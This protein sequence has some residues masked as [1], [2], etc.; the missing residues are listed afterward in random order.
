VTPSVP[1]A[2]GFKPRRC[3]DLAQELHGGA[4]AVGA[5]DRGDGRQ[6]GADRSAPRWLPRAPAGSSLPITGTDAWCPGGR[7]HGDGALLDGHGD[8]LR[9]VRWT[10]GSAANRSPGWT[11]RLSSARPVISRPSAPAGALSL[12]GSSSD[13]RRIIAGPPMRLSGSGAG[14]SDRAAM[15]GRGAN[16]SAT[17]E[18]RASDRRR[19]GL[20]SSTPAS[21]RMISPAAGMAVQ[22]A[23]ANPWVSAVGWGRSIE[24]VSTYCGSSNG[25]TA[26]KVLK[27]CLQSTDRRYPFRRAGLARHCQARHIRGSGLGPRHDVFPHHPST[28]AATLGSSPAR[29]PRFRPARRGAWSA[30]HK[31]RHWPAP[32]RPPSA[33]AG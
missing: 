13:R 6:A 21:A 14:S 24:T 7:K 8:E 33:P 5:G 20:M 27:G 32:H 9:A 28:W 31:P 16:S 23:V 29:Q 1:S 2:S 25:N 4:L 11:L 30:G 22:P 19:D 15:R 12:S 17:T 26:T 3:P 10:P 18:T